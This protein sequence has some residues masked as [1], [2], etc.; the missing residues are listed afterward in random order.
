LKFPSKCDLKSLVR[1]HGQV[2]FS[3][4]SSGWVGLG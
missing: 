3:D 2:Y 1:F 4:L